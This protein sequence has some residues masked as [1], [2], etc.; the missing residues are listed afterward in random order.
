MGMGTMT[1]S[2]EILAQSDSVAR[3]DNYSHIFR[4]HL[5]YCPSPHRLLRWYNPEHKFRRELSDGDRRRTHV[6]IDCRTNDVHH[7]DFYNDPCA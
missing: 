1:M 7:D 3:C 6:F 4:S 2:D 5:V